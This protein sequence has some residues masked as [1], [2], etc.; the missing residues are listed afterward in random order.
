MRHC[1]MNSAEAHQHLASINATAELFRNAPKIRREVAGRCFHV[2]GDHDHDRTACGND[3][4]KLAHH[5][6][7]SDV[8]EVTC[9]DC[10][11][12]ESWIE[13]RLMEPKSLQLGRV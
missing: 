13:A 10:R 3:P 7:T 8:D 4:R 11:R 5:E 6:V 9:P 1:T 2:P 12:D